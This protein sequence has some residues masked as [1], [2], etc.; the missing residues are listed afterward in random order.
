ME[1]VESD[2]YEEAVHEIKSQM[3]EYYIENDLYWDDEAKL[4]SYKDCTLWK[5]ID[6]EEIGFIM[7]HDNNGDFYIAELHI[8]S[9][10]RNKGFGSKAIMKA[11]EFAAALGF[12]DIRIRAMKSSPAYNLY[13]RSGFTME[14]ELPFTYQ[15]V[16]KTNNNFRQATR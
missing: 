13:L 6:S 9:Q 5:I 16:S 3:I 7:M 12:E 4:K 11:R 2:K 15:L 8:S 10:Y 1:F 14:K